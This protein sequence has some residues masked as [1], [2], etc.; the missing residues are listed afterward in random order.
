M[1]FAIISFSGLADSFYKRKL[2]KWKKI[3][4]GYKKYVY[5]PIRGFRIRLKNM[6]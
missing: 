3:Y 6:L 2:K 4:V 1:S 5:W